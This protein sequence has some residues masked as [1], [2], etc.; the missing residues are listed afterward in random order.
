MDTISN[1]FTG[2]KVKATEMRMFIDDVEFPAEVM[3]LTSQVAKDQIEWYDSISK[4]RYSVE[5]E[6]NT[7]E[8][9]LED[10][11]EAINSL[12]E[13]SYHYVVVFNKEGFEEFKESMPVELKENADKISSIFGM[14]VRV[15]A[16]LEEKVAIY[17]IPLGS[18]GIEGVL[19]LWNF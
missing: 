6:I 12:P 7:N 2:K 19:D 14:K 15:I 4:D 11:Y 16:G 17:K 8:T 5:C 13:M 10:L 1:E 9:S 3:T 18:E